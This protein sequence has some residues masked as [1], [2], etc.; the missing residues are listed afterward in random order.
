MQTPSLPVLSCLRIEKLST[1]KSGLNDESAAQCSRSLLEGQ[2]S[3]NQSCNIC[4]H[5]ITSHAPITPF[6][7]FSV[8][9]QL[10][11]GVVCTAVCNV[12]VKKRPFC[13]LQQSSLSAMSAQ[14][15]PICRVQNH[16]VL[17]RG[18]FIANRSRATEPQLS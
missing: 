15:T 1:D 18:K 11:S 2:L 7:D 8:H 9:M 6:S 5:W 4:C 16:C 3:V 13:S 14:L 17:V 10:N 12:H